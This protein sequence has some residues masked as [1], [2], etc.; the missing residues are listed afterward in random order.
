[1][2]KRLMFVFAT[3]IL[4][5]GCLHAQS[6]GLRVNVPFEFVAGN[7]VLPPG[8]YTIKPIGVRADIVLLRSMDDPKNAVFIV[9]C[10]AD[11]KEKEHDSELVFQVSGGRYSLWQIWTRDYDDGREFFVKPTE[12]QEANVADSHVVVIKATA[13]AIQP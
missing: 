11:R 2:S 10:A 6:V 9:P 13:I 4:V 3:L 12:T 1:M 7:T 5:T 8:T